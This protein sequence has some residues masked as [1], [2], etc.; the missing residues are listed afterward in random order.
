[1]NRAVFHGAVSFFPESI[2]AVLVTILGIAESLGIPRIQSF[3][4]SDCVP[5]MTR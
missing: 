1:M 4:T 3:C 5:R 2:L